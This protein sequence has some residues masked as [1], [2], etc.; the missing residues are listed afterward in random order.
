[1]NTVCYR[2]AVHCAG[3]L[4]S[5]LRE[6]GDLQT[7]PSSI[8][9]SIA[10]EHWIAYREFLATHLHQDGRAVNK[11]NSDYVGLFSAPLEDEETYLEALEKSF[12]FGDDY[13]ESNPDVFQLLLEYHDSYPSPGP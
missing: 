10:H 9:C 8:V 12:F 3:P 6:A 5:C 4:P 2:Q 13:W 11:E 1:M 7:T